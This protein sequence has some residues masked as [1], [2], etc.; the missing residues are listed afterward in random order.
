[1]AYNPFVAVPVTFSIT[2]FYSHLIGAGGILSLL[3][4]YF[5]ILGQILLNKN[6]FFYGITLLL[7]GFSS[8][9]FLDLQIWV[10]F[11]FCVVLQKKLKIK[12]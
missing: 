4:F 3:F 10:C 2:T 6:T 11:A 8:G 7:L 9:G 12:I 1:M 5:V